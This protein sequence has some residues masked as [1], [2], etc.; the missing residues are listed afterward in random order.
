MPREKRVLVENGCYHVVNRGNQKQTIFYEE[1]DYENYLKILKHYKIKYGFKVLGYCLM[2]NHI[3]IFMQPNEQEKLP[4]IM[5][6]VT[7]TYTIWFNRKYNKVGRLWQGRFKNMVINRDEYFVKCI[8]YIEENPVRAGIT[9]HPGDYRW[10]SYRARVFGS[11]DT[12][13]NITYST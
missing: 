4:L 2:P 12:V 9:M 1:A 8:S 13:L 10:S 6:G 11:K 5:Q 7:Q 3:H